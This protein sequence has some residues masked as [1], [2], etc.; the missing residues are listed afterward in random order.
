MKL[1]SL[2]LIAAPHQHAL[3]SPAS[4]SHDA[5]LALANHG[6]IVRF[7][8]GKKAET[9]SDFYDEISAAMQFPFYFG[10]NWDAFADCIGDLEWLNAKAG[11]IVVFTD[12]AHLLKAAP[13]ADATTLKRILTDTCTR[14]NGPKKIPFH[15]VFQ[16]DSKEATDLLKRW[17]GL[18]TIV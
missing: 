8:R 16:T 15:V 3:L 11:V 6:S 1:D 18:E 9:V 13:A 2:T 12:A 5:L 4:E 7:V 14:W 10:G 17:P